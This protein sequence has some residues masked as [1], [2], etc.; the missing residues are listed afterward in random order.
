MRRFQQ[1]LLRSWVVFFIVVIVIDLIA[2]ENGYSLSIDYFTFFLVVALSTI[3][4][5]D[6]VRRR[7]M[8]FTFHFGFVL[9][10]FLTYGL[11]SAI[12]VGQLTM[13]IYQLRS[14]HTAIGR[15]R[16]LHNYP[17]NVTL[18]LL[19]ILPAGLAYN[20][21]GGTH[22]PDFSLIGNIV[23]LVTMVVIM[24]VVL[25][26][27]YTLSNFLL[28]E[29][30]PSSVMIP[31][32]RFEAVVITAELLFGVFSTLM[33]QNNGISALVMT[34]FALFIIK[35]AL[36]SSVHASD[37][38]EHW[39]QIERLK[40]A[41]WQ[42]GDSQ[43]IIERYLKQLNQFVKPDIAW[44]KFDFGEGKTVYYSLKD[45]RK[46]KADHVE[47][48]IIEELIE[49]EEVLLYGMQQEWDIRL[50]DCLP[51]ETQSI[52]FIK[53]EATETI[54]CSLFLASE[55]S[56]EFTTDFGYELYRALRVLSW[57]VERAQER[58]HLLIDSRT[59]AMTK[60]P[61]YRA[62]QEWGDRR[63]KQKDLYPFSA[64]MIDLDHFK[65]INDTHGHEIGDVVLFE[66]AKLLM[67]ATRI[68]DLVA[69]YGGEEFVV[70]L[71]NTDIE[72]ARIVA[73]RIRETLH[74]NPIEVSGHSLEITA[75]IGIDTLKELGDLASLIRNAD[76]AM[77]VGA[78]FQGRDRVASYQEWKEK[79]I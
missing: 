78:K 52:L 23:P 77:Y 11:L 24:W 33:A 26:F 25:L 58:Q 68:T 19:L 44:I 14:F 47:G 64:L 63:I 3:F 1:Y 57:A 41:A 13:L 37:R 48:I 2:R 46:L 36:G 40:E 61:N 9:Y 54:N 21:L 7:H 34:A 17:F 66:V 28:G 12:C 59:D 79:V 22:G 72:S 60:L 32:L 65:Q 74:A 29:N 45:G 55:A 35:R 20:A 43:F 39:E 6:P 38:I 76:R 71:P 67:Q 69:R 51:E 42:D 31:L 56:G 4:V 18:E 8:S 53:P 15:R 73:E 5:V 62:L 16:M 30:I 10:T 50:Y 49:K 75:S 27:Q 70:L